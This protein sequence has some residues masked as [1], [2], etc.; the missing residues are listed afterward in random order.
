MT[1]LERRE[2]IYELC[3]QNEDYRG[4]KQQYDEANRKFTKIT[5]KLPKKLRNFL[6]SVPTMGYFVHHRML[7]VICEY[8]RFPD[9]E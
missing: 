7:N 8:M 9:E 6:W 3:E 2:R 1:E 5:D 4:W